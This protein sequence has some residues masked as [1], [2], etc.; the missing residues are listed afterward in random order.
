MPIAPEHRWSYPIDWRELSA[1]IRFTRAKGRCERCGR[2][3]GEEVTHLDDGV[4]WDAQQGAWRDGCGRRVRTLPPPHAL[5]EG[6]PSLTGIPL[7]RFCP[8]R[9]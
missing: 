4:W 3:Q 6:Q 7:P 2:P 8:S 1:L 5:E 9:A